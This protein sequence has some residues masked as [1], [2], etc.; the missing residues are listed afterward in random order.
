M[1]GAVLWFVNLCFLNFCLAANNL[2]S[3]QPTYITRYDYLD[4][5]KILTNERILKRLMDCLME[6]GPCT[7]EGKE[8]KRKFFSVFSSHSVSLSKIFRS[9][10]RNTSIQYELPLQRMSIV[11]RQNASVNPAR[12]L[13]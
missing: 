7:R 5:D 11:R 10:F 4:I 13:E 1:A 8:L 3:A 2:P 12:Y 6:R 9:A